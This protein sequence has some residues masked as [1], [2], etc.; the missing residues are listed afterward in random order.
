MKSAFIKAGV[1]TLASIVIAIVAAPVYGTS[2]VNSVHN[3]SMSGPGAVRATGQT[4][5][6]IFCHTPHNAN[7]DAYYLWNRLDPA[8]PYT[9]YGSSTLK[10]TVGQPTGSSRLCLSCHDGTIALGAV[11]SQPAIMPF[12][13]SLSGRKSNLGTNLADDHPVSFDYNS[14]VLLSNSQLVNAGSLPSVVRL[15][16][17]GQMQ[18]TACHNPHNDQYGKFL[19]IS[20]LKS[21]LCTACHSKTNWSANSHATSPKTWNGT[22]T[23]PWPSSSYT[24]VAG[25]ACGNCHRPHSA[26]GKKRLLNY[27]EEETNCLV[28]HNGKVA[29]K[30]IESELLKLYKHPVATF[31][32]VHDPSENYSGSE[33]IHVEC[34]DCHNP[35]QVNNSTSVKPKVPGQLAGVPGVDLNTNAYKATAVNEY[36]ICFKCHGDLSNNVLRNKA[37]EIPR[38]WTNTRDN[39]TK[40][41]GV[42]FH[43]IVKPLEKIT[44][45]LLVSPWVWGSM[46]YCTDCHGSDSGSIRGSHGSIYKHILIA[47]YETSQDRSGYVA[48]DYALCFKCHNYATLTGP[49][50]KF[51]QHQKHFNAGE[52]CTYCH[53]PHGSPTNP[54]MINFDVRP[55]NGTI[56]AVVTESGGKPIVL[57]YP[58]GNKNTCVLTCHGKVHGT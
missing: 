42:S 18:C 3:L 41:T 10:A 28:C 58:L 8:G 25:N 12:T 43:P 38:Y 9:P 27:E 52:R 50:S 31:K 57:I 47:K 13:M 39:R 46:V 1:M 30:D 23:D 37:I 21:G 22:G 56:P 19:A 16:A 20:N 14:A 33:P 15:D 2:V 11:L 24:T 34:S 54:G 7:P 49:N 35:H 4:E 26:P 40:F 44:D 29:A 45:N 36:E 53:D 6:C 51:K 55:Q 48:G 32:G 17:T 5:I